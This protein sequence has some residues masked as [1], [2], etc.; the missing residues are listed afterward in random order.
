MRLDTRVSARTRVEVV[1]EGVLTRMLEE[2]PALA[3]RVWRSFE[4][5][6]P[7]VT[8]DPAQRF[9]TLGGTRHELWGAALSAF[10]RHP[11]TAEHGITMTR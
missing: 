1:T 8:G 6:T 7:A 9:G 5:P 4:Q 11:L 10:R 2:D 3:N